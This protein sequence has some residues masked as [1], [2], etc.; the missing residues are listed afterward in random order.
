MKEEQRSDEVRTCETCKY[1]Y[2]LTDDA[3]FVTYYCMLYPGL[4]VGE[5]DYLVGSDFAKACENYKS[6]KM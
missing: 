1:V 6:V 3:G 5:E 4:V 2:G